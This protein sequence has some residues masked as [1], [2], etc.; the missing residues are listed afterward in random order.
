MR[1]EK[2]L[3]LH[4]ANK[5]LYAN[6][7]DKNTVSFCRSWKSL[8]QSNEPL[9][10]QINGLSGDVHIANRFSDGFSDIYRKNDVTSHN[11]LRHEFESI[12]PAYHD[13]HLHDNISQFYFSRLDMEDMISKL[14]EGKSY[15]GFIRAE[16]IIHGSPKLFVH[17]FFLQCYVTA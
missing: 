7:I 11:S 15:A 8:S 1:Q 17:L 2:R 5:K 16:H 12:F 10:P 14:R 13:A 6:L 9:P 4:E 3:K